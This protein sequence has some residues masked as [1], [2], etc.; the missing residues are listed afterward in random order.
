MPREAIYGSTPYIDAS[1]IWWGI[2]R[3]DPY[4]T[5]E[6]VARE[7]SGVVKGTVNGIPIAQTLLFDATPCRFGNSR[8]WI[9][10]PGCEQRVRILYRPTSSY[11]FLCRRCQDLTYETCNRSRKQ[12]LYPLP[13]LWFKR[14]QRKRLD[15]K[16]M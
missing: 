4:V 10:C 13:L 9:I 16:M 5:A 6:E 12:R 8:L 7:K 14:L 2:K 15:V 1:D 11:R 3:K